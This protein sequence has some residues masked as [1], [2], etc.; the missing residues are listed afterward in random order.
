MCVGY[1]MAEMEEKTSMVIRRPG[2][3][4]FLEIKEFVKK[5]CEN[6]RNTYGEHDWNETPLEEGTYEEMMERFGTGNILLGFLEDTLSGIV[7]L[8][9]KNAEK[10]RHVG[11]LTLSLLEDDLIG[12]L[13]KELISRMILTCK[14]KG[15]IR[16][17]NLRVREDLFKIQDIYKSLGFYEEGSLAR[18]V[19]L[20]GMFYSTLLFGRSID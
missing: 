11:N 15:V 5:T 12:T 20:N 19:C 16:K 7:V 6:T 8:T 3:D 10:F 18:D 17:V 9:Q 14:G 2:P 1:K 4:D 13:G